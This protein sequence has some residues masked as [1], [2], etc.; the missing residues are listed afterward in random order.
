MAAGAIKAGRAYVEFFADTTKFTAGLSTVQNRLQKVSASIATTGAALS[1]VG[2]AGVAGFAPMIQAA[3]DFQESLNVFGTVFEDN[4]DAMRAWSNQTAKMLGR[5]EAQIVQFASRTG[6]QLQGFGFNEEMSREMSKSLSTLAVDMASFFNTADTDALDALMS[7][8]RGEADPIERYNVNV[9]EA[10]VN[11]KL[12]QQSIDPKSATDA[13]KAFARYAIIMEQTKLAQGDVIRTS[14]G[15]ANQ[16]KRLQSAAKDAAIAIG[17]PLQDALAGIMKSFS[18]VTGSIIQMIQNNPQ[19]IST[20][21]MVAVGVAAVGAGL[22][23]L[24]GLFAA[25][26]LAIRTLLSPF[27][28]LSTAI[29]LLVPLFSAL[30]SP[31]GLVVAAVAL[32]STSVIKYLGGLQPI[33]DW[34]R[35]QFDAMVGE[36]STA[37]TAIM[38]ALQKGDFGAAIEVAMAGMNLGFTKAVSQM[39]IAWAGFAAYFKETFAKA[40]YA[41]P[42]IQLGVSAQLTKGWARMVAA[43]K[44]L[45]VENVNNVAKDQ[46]SAQ[47]DQAEARLKQLRD[48]GKL[49]ESDFN[50]RMGSLQKARE[51]DMSNLDK[52]AAQD[53]QKID[54]ERINAVNGANQAARAE[55][56]ALKAQMDA[57]VNAIRGNTDSAA[58]DAQAKLDGAKKRYQEALAAAETVVAAPGGTEAPPVPGAY[59]SPEEL[60]AQMAKLQQATSATDSAKQRASAGPLFGGAMAGQVFGAGDTAKRQ[61]KAQQDSLSEARKTNELLK[62]IENKGAALVMG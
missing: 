61:L 55:L 34:F 24:A 39:K 54:R 38:N 32:L 49:T 9:K 12:L 20:L 10:A 5:S 30:A 53:Q 40:A 2:A 45:Y 42:V 48:E 37:V 62:K 44:S 7:A 27:S 17:T 1:A 35:A 58:A 43:M 18:G 19:V 16:L 56:D 11:S 22:V 46:S 59:A 41:L 14:D 4:T 29:G 3:S 15:F 47:F 28:L 33:F 26:G 8:F 36:V 21:A 13:Q 25:A 51:A 50:S 23:G 57:E 31:I 6:A 52:Q 60:Q